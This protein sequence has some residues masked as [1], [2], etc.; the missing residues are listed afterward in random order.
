MAEDTH[1][2]LKT[3]TTLKNSPGTSSCNSF[4]KVIIKSGITAMRRRRIN[5]SDEETIT[6]ANL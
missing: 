4:K 6:T 3:D 1:T 2:K 5:D